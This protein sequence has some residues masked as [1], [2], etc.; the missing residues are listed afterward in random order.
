MPEALLSL[1]AG[2]LRSYRSHAPLFTKFCIETCDFMQ[3]NGQLLQALKPEDKLRQ[4][5]FAVTMLDRLDS[6]PRF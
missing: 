2:L 6:D 3:N 4:K 1:F 5:E